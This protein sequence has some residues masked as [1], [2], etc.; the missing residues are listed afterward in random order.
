MNENLGWITL[1][2]KILNSEVWTDKDLFRI[3]IWCLLKANHK[4]TRFIHGNK[5]IFIKAG[6]FVT[7]GLTGSR[8]VGISHSSFWRKLK[9]LQAMDNIRLI[10]FSQYSIVEINNWNEY[11]NVKKMKNNNSLNTNTLDKVSE[12]SWKADGKQ[13]ETDNNVNNVNNTYLPENSKNLDALAKKM[14][15]ESSLKDIKDEDISLNFSEELT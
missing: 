13:M 5:R 11:Q 10:C 15:F 9:L 3:W 2:R 6:S 8:E 12:E 7:G 4:D 14:I 1:H